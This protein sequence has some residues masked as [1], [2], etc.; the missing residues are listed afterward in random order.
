MDSDPPAARPWGRQILRTLQR[1]FV[2]G[3]LVVVPVTVTV[4]VL[5]FLF[6]K[7]D[8]L[9][10][11]ILARYLQHQIPGMGLLAT[12]LL[13]FLVGVIA[14][15]V[16]GSRLF[17]L[18]ELIF[19]RTPL[20]RAVYTAAKQLL[21][22]IT[23]TER[24]A[25]SRA[26][27]IQYPRPGLYTVGFVSSRP[28]VRAGAAEEQMVAVFVPSTPT[29]VTGF[30]VLVPESEVF[31]LAMTTEEAVKFIVSGGFAAP[32]VIERTAPKLVEA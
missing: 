29:P 24:K 22:A 21:E 26:V 15:N 16:L 6:Q 11:P 1:V 5:Y 3:V 17:G 27:M 23:S 4:Y 7:V 18:G 20:V 2:S 14:R 19:V 13:I 9:L 30:V 8:G 31:D 32:T 12:L 25:F 28:R 10:S